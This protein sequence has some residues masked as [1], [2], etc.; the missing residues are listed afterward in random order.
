[1]LQPTQL[2]RWSQVTIY[3]KPSTYSI[4]LALEGVGTPANT[5][6]GRVSKPRHRRAEFMPITKAL[7]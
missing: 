5:C 6:K 7:R 1:M 2:N 4:G 3:A